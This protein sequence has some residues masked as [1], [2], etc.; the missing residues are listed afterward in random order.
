M[1]IIRRKTRKLSSSQ[2]DQVRR[3]I[4]NSADAVRLMGCAY[5]VRQDGTVQ[6]INKTSKEA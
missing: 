6:F 5:V 4:A 2:L 3:A 1:V